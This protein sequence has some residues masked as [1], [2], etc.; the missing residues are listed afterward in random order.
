MSLISVTSNPSVESLDLERIKWKIIRE[1]PTIDSE[2][3]DTVEREYKRF[4][5]LKILFPE[6]SFT[7]TRN[8]D[9]MWHAHILDT[10]N[11]RRDCDELFGKF[12]N[13]RPYFGPH[14]S[15]GIYEGMQHT[16]GTLHH[17]YH[18][19]FSEYPAADLDEVKEEKSSTQSYC[20]GHHDN[21]AC[22]DDDDA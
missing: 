6:Q 14:S 21:E 12:L 8:M 5:T 19:I 11:Y 15:N 1:H 20:S 10:A 4:L 3:I 9:L 17:C 7:P 22:D 18:E 16:L 2:G 13:H